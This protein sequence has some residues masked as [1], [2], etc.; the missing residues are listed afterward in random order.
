MK[1]YQHP[2]IMITVLA[3]E[4]VMTLSVNTGSEFYVEWGSMFPS[5]DMGMDT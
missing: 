1:H 2:Q 5:S 3:T 4:D